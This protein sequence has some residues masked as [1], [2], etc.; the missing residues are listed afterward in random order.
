MQR[1]F[2]YKIL[3]PS[4]IFHRMKNSH[5]IILKRNFNASLMCMQSTWE[6]M[7][8]PSQFLTWWALVNGEQNRKAPKDYEAST[9]SMDVSRCFSAAP[10]PDSSLWAKRKWQQG[11]KERQRLSK[12]NL[13][14]SCHL[15]ALWL[16]E[17]CSS[18]CKSVQPLHNEVI[19]KLRLKT[20]QSSF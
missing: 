15:E 19:Y 10:L 4:Q 16:W 20:T 14:L 7:T 9:L 5:W 13:S 1:L 11:K 6:P 3:K 12:K 8:S 17:S 18:A 2:K